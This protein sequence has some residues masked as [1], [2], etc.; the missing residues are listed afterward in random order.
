MRRIDMRATGALM[1]CAMLMAVA[2]VLATPDASWAMVILLRIQNG[3]GGILVEGDSTVP[4]HEGEIELLGVSFRVT[5]PTTIGSAT[6][7]AGTGKASFSEIVVTKRVDK[8][9]PKLFL[10]AANGTHYPQALITFFDTNKKG[11][12]LLRFTIELTTVFVS[13]YQV[14]GNL[15][16]L[17]ESISFAVGKIKLTEAASGETAVWDQTTNSAE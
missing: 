16:G 3:Q 7:G 13:S 12:L 15:D 17:S 1:V 8:A 11:Q 9:S 4:G 5:N 2:G 6:G 10:T 14:G